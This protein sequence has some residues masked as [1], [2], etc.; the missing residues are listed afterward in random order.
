MCVCIYIKCAEE[1]FHFYETRCI[2]TCVRVLVC[3]SVFIKVNIHEGISRGLIQNV[4]FNRIKRL[5]DFILE[6]TRISSLRS[7]K[8]LLVFDKS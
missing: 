8:R 3:V 1:V 7:M 4:F 5:F 6:K 2:H